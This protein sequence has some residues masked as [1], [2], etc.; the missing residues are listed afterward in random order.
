MLLAITAQETRQHHV[1]R[2]TSMRATCLL[3]I[4]GDI[5][6]RTCTATATVACA[7]VPGFMS[8]AVSPQVR[9]KLSIFLLV[10]S[11]HSILSAYH[12]ST[13]YSSTHESMRAHTMCVQKLWERHL[14][15][16]NT[17][18]VS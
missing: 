11:D 2:V 5:P 7:D 6:L 1:Q 10:N 18:T 4:A 3:T 9:Y 16:N 15:H 12:T 17:P 8:H 14:I 13:T